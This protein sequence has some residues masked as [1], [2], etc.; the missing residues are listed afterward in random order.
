MDS[1]VNK[2]VS[3]GSRKDRERTKAKKSEVWQKG[4]C[5]PV[6]ERQ[7]RNSMKKGKGARTMKKEYSTITGNEP[8]AKSLLTETE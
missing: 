6:G 2:M 5:R 4:L 3:Q 8:L 1:I 7:D